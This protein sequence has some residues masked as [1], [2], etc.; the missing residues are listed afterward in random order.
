MGVVG[1]AGPADCERVIM[2]QLTFDFRRIQIVKNHWSE[3][4]HV[5]YDDGRVV[6]PRLQPTFFRDPYVAY[7]WCVDHGLAGRLQK[8]PAPGKIIWVPDSEFEV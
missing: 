7:A 4:W 1:A 8:K 6:L 5:T 3:A 2:D